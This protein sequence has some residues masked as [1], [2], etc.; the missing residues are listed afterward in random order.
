MVQDLL[1]IA[2]LSAC[3]LLLFASAEIAYHFFK[4]Q[5]EYTRKFVHI[6]TGILTMFFPLLLTSHWSVLL[7]CGSFWV[8]L[9]LSL[10]FNFLK[11]IN[12]INRKSEGSVLYPIVVYLI[13]L[14]YIW[15]SG[16]CGNEAYLYFYLP[17]LT[18][19]ICDP[20]AALVGKRWGVKKYR[21]A[22]DVKSYIGSFAFMVASLV[23]SCAMYYLNGYE[24]TIKISLT[25]ITIAAF[26]TLAE[27]I[28]RNGYDN[29]SIPL[30]VALV[31]TL[32]R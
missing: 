16:I 29:L 30:T 24:I 10:K 11:S 19:A 21:F 9:Q 20:I 2:I 32:F 27:A 13:F 31:L 1:Y 28:S 5:A 23:L 4:V 12:A 18:M 6:G 15:S 22:S 8:I 3:F 7:L 14:F 26:A 17:I 25:I